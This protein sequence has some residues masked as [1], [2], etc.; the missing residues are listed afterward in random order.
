[1]V[2]DAGTLLRPSDIIGQFDWR[3]QQDSYHK[4]SA[5]QDTFNPISPVGLNER[6]R[7][8]SIDED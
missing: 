6:A 8:N 1:M 3:G 7:E 5:A 4:I 2:V